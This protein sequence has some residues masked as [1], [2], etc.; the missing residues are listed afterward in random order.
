MQMI[1]KHLI[2]SRLSNLCLSNRVQNDTSVPASVRP[3]RRL[4]PS[5]FL[6][7]ELCL[8]FALQLQGLI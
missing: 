7:L 5:L 4:L 2:S 1:R 8:F 3:A 6:F